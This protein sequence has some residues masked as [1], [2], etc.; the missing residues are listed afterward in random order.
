MPGRTRTMKGS[1]SKKNR[2][3]SGRKWKKAPRTRRGYQS[4]ARTRGGAV[5]GEMKHFN[6]SNSVLLVASPTWVGTG[7][8]PAIQGCL[9]C[10]QQG[11]ADSQRIG[12]AVKLMSLKMRG[13]AFFPA[14]QDN[15]GYAKT[16]SNC[17]FLLVQDMQANS[18]NIDGQAVMSGAASTDLVVHSFQKIDNFG[19]FRVLKDFMVQLQNPNES[20]LGKGNCEVGKNF[21]FTVKFKGGLDVRF[22]NTNGGSFADIIDNSFHFIGVTTSTNLQPQVD[23]NCRACFK[24]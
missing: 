6:L 16:A 10:P 8:D 21:K 4:V 24:E 14:T 15:T 20:D 18:S 5:T 17:R 12:K 2:R 23:W 19:R 7:L 13:N 11:S 9:F 1:T 3:S 22:N